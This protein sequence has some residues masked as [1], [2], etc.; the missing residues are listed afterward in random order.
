MFCK[1]SVYYPLWLPPPLHSPPTAPASKQDLSAPPPT[2]QNEEGGGGGGEEGSGE[3]RQRRLKND[4]SRL[5]S[6]G[7]TNA[8]RYFSSSSGAAGVRLP[9]NFLLS[10]LLS[11]AT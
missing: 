5:F 10:S 11:F 3:R 9:L 2:R 8:R 4:G 1:G 7:Q 6:P